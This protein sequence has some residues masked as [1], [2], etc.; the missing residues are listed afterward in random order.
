MKNSKDWKLTQRNF[1]SILFSNVSINLSVNQAERWKGQ[2]KQ[3]NSIH[4][5][6]AAEKGVAAME[7]GEDRPQMRCDL[8]GVLFS[9]MRWREG[10]E[11]RAENIPR[12]KDD[13]SSD[14]E[15]RQCL[16]RQ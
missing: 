8:T 9:D 4:V 13:V 3:S 6:E 2:Q 1:A 12:A 15:N 16:S 10:H 7:T 11:L 14:T 5:L